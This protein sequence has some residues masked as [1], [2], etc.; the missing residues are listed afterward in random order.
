MKSKKQY[1]SIGFTLGLGLLLTFSMLMLV[2][3][4]R[5][6]LSQSGSGIIRVAPIGSDT[7]GC[8][9]QATPCQ[10]I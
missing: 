9:S 8:G 5:V 2:G 4:S 3:G 6:A 1:L 7:P 10:T